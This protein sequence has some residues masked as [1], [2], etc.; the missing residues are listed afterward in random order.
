LFV[1]GIKGHEVACLG[2]LAIHNLQLHLSAYGQS[3]EKH[4]KAIENYSSEQV[5]QKK[6]S[7]R[8]ELGLPDIHW[9]GWAYRNHRHETC[10]SP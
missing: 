8:R 4:K 1:A 2:K 6:E 10:D 3:V 9:Q 5:T 7:C